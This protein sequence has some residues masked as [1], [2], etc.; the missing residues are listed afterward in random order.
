ME[1]MFSSPS[2]LFTGSVAVW[3][4]YLLHCS[5]FVLM[6]L[7]LVWQWK[8]PSLAVN[9]TETHVGTKVEEDVSP[10]QCLIVIPAWTVKPF[11]CFCSQGRDEPLKAFQ[12]QRC[13]NRL[14]W[15]L[16][17]AVYAM[18]SLYP[19]PHLN[20]STPTLTHFV[21][22]VWAMYWCWKKK[23]KSSQ[24][25]PQWD[26]PEHQSAPQNKEVDAPTGLK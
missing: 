24:T 3:N 22:Q 13:T 10:L 11:R 23:K 19:P 6:D 21:L 15:R 14:P 26:M 7:F 18:K 8:H 1:F 25:S 12:T 20:L 4:S 16:G 9:C 5:V 2:F 17:E